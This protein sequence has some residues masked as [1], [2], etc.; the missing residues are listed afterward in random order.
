[1]IDQFEVDRT[2]LAGRLHPSQRSRVV[3]GALPGGILMTVVALAILVLIFAAGPF[4]AVFLAY[5]IPVYALLAGGLWLV[6]RRARDL[7]GG[8]VVAYTGWT[9][10][11]VP[12]RGVIADRSVQ[13]YGKKV[14]R[15]AGNSVFYRVQVGD[16]I[17]QVDER[18]Y[19]RTQPN[20]TNTVFLTSN[21]HR[22]LNI[23][24][25]PGR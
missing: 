22:V 23:V 18:L 1:M 11:E 12:L 7:A 21:T 16:R 15:G 2:N 17:F 3:G 13:T 14:F 4:E 9:G 5:L 19:A 10:Q 24:R 25:T 20:C 6:V 8:T